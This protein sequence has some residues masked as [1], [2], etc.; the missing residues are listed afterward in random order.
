M[1]GKQGRGDQ[2]ISWIHVTD[3]CRSVEF[4]INS[5][6]SGSVNITT[7]N[8]KSNKDFMSDLR[9]QLSMPFGISQPVWLLELASSII[10]TETELLL[11]SRYVYPQRLM[12]AGF[13][14]E[15]DT[16]EECLIGLI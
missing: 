16:V 15:Y 14:F 10:K 11:K 12:D 8:P 3:F 4:L 13:E 1:G 2:F 6:I 5:E 7:P 9:K